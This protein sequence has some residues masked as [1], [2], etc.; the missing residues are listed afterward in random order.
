MQLYY[1]DLYSISRSF[2]SNCGAQSVPTRLG[3][4]GPLPRVSRILQ[5]VNFQTRIRPV[6]SV[7]S[8]GF[9]GSP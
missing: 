5:H 4:S 7:N 9:K 1:I 3:N 6:N 2:P 8:E